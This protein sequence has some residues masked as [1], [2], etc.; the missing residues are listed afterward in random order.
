MG[1]NA[2]L[3][4]FFPRED[5]GG[6][7]GAWS[8]RGSPKVHSVFTVRGIRESKAVMI[9][10]RRN[11]G[12]KSTGDAG[13]GSGKRVRVMA[14]GYIKSG[15]QVRPVLLQGSSGELQGQVRGAMQA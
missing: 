10:C 14:L 13:K 12:A 4:K 3:H 8:A 11:T 5:T 9:R 1:F 2:L 6:P 15:E 7:E